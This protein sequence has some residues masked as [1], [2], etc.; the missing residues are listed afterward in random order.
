[1]LTNNTKIIEKIVSELDNVN[2]AFA[3]IDRKL[4]RALRLAV[5]DFLFF[6]SEKGMFLFACACEKRK[7]NFKNA[8]G[9]L[10]AGAVT[11]VREQGMPIPRLNDYVKRE[12]VI[13]R[14]RTVRND[15]KFL[16]EFPA[17]EKHKKEILPLSKEQT[18]KKI[19][20]TLNS[21]EKRG[22]NNEVLIE[23]ENLLRCWINEE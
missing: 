13:A 7:I 3:V 22:G 9:Y 11:I 12:D 15:F 8:L 2:T 18:A 17:P 16:S 20:S 23:V 10:T 1:M 21:L 5:N 19:R 14:F 4:C 6:E